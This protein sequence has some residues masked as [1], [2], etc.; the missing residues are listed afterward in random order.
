MVLTYTGFGTKAT[1]QTEAIPGSDQVPNNAGGYAWKV[2]DWQRLDRFLT[3]GS[4]GGS[5]Y[6][7]ERE[8][9]RQNAQAVARC[10]NA[11]G[12]R[13]VGRIVAISEAGRAPKNEPALFALA[14]AAGTGDAETRATALAVLPRVAR[15]GTHLLH[16]VAYVEQFRGWGRGLRRAIGDWFNAR[17]A[18]Q[19]AYQAIKYQSRDKWAL[20]DLLRLSHPKPA[21]EAHRAIYKWIVDGMADEHYDAPY[22]TDRHTP[23]L[24]WGFEHAKRATTPMEMAGLITTHRLPREAVPTAMLKDAV[25]WEALLGDMPYTAMMRNLA[26]MTRV[27]LLPP[28]GGHT[29]T[30]AERLMD[31]DAMRKARVHP[32]AILAALLTYQQGKG[33][34]GH[35]TWTPLKRIV[36]ALDS[37]FYASFGA[38]EPTGKRVLVAVDVSGSMANTKV[39]GLPYMEAAT[40]AGAFALITA[41]TEPEHVFVAFNTTATPL[42]VSPRERLDD[43]VKRIRGR[44]GGGTDCASPIT[45]A[46][47][48]N[49]PVDAFVILTDSESWA[50]NTH[51]AQA[52]QAYRRKTG[53]PAKMVV[54][55]MA[56]NHASVADPGDAGVLDVVGMDTAVPALVADFI[57][58]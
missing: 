23:A 39:A 57:R 4:E 56:S 51:P 15:I 50:G 19:L 11:D 6:V 5:Y 22:G 27:G 18:G 47:D 17:E 3:L 44:L 8:L 34:R 31:A 42:D 16:F 35:Q 38:V 43:V 32:L 36:D 46:G 28:M 7:G 24:V 14:M 49:V 45:W 12:P 58:S 33:E 9:T 20:S 2:D 40:A 55:A 30:V 25:V 37:A 29:R 54:V 21:S 26:T 52:I 53:I 41:A 13:V 10:L 1:P 48:N